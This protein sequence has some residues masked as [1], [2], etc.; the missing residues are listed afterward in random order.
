M[1]SDKLFK[2]H[3]AA[4]AEKKNLEERIHAL[5][6]RIADL[7]KE[8]EEAASAGNVEAYKAANAEANDLG[9]TL[10]VYRKKRTT[11]PVTPEMARDAW[12]EYS[13]GYA[14]EIRKKLSA[15]D[16]ARRA[17]CD[18][19]EAAV[20][21]QNDALVERE[22]LA[23]ISGIEPEDLDLPAAI[24]DKSAEVPCNIRMRGPEFAYF[25]GSGLWKCH[26]GVVGYHA[27]DT[28]NAVVRNRKPV[29]DPRF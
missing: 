13:S 15:Y 29:D 21:C 25:A 19:F 17:A 18:A 16:K 26:D 23:E 24:E 2:M 20:V 5:E 6:A 9:A 7:K 1:K 27:L 22:R 11:T 14:S 28:I 3:E 8:A 10:F 4:M 12:I